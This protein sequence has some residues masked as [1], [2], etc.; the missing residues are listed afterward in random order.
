MINKSEI[1]AIFSEA[2]AHAALQGDYDMRQ[3]ADLLETI[4]SQM[5]KST[6]FEAWDHLSLEFMKFYSESNVKILNKLK[7]AYFDLLFEQEFNKIEECRKEN[8]Q[9]GISYWTE[10]YGRAAVNFRDDLISILCKQRKQWPGQEKVVM[11]RYAS[12]ARYMQ[13]VRWVDAFDLYEEIEKNEELPKDVRAIAA[14]ILFE[15]VLYY[16]PDYTHAKPYL[17]SA[18]NLCPDHYIVM[19][20]W[21]EWYVKTGDYQRARDQ[22]LQVLIQKSTDYTAQNFMGDSFVSE[23]KLDNAEFWFNTARQNNFL[24]SES[25]RRL[26]NLFADKSLFAGKKEEVLKL[27]EQILQI[28][29]PIQSRLVEKGLAENRFFKQAV[30]YHTYRDVAAA[31]FGNGDFTNSEMWYS[32]AIEEDP[33]LTSALID[34]ANLKVEQKEPDLDGANAMFNKVLQ[35]DPNTY[36][37][38]WGLARVHERQ[39][40]IESALGDFQKCLE[41]RPNWGDWIN[42]F[43]GNLYYRMKDFEKAIGFYE[44]A[45]QSNPSYKAYKENLVD[46]MQLRAEQLE[47]SNPVK[48]QELMEKAAESLE[49]ANNWNKLGNFYYRREEYSLAADQY[50]KAIDLNKSEPVYWE[51]KGL[52]L[53]RLQNN[54]EA[55]QCYHQ[56]EALDGKTGKYLNRIGYFLFSNNR[57]N[58]AVEYYLK[59][60]E[61]E[62]ENSI[63]LSNTGLA[64][65]RLQDWD[66]AIRYYELLIQ[67]KP[68]DHQTLNGIGVIYHNKKDYFRA[69]E[70][71]KR[72]LE[73]KKEWLYYSNIALAY[74]YLGLVN[75]AI[76]NY[77]LSNELNPDD[78]Y[79][80]N[81]LG[82]LYYNA[83]RSDEAIE[84]YKRSITL[85]PNDGVLYSNLGLALIQK[86]NSEEVIRVIED[87]P[88]DESQKKTAMSVVAPY[89]TPSSNIIN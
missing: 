32:K 37:A 30:V 11:E 72:A 7:T 5:G 42:N 48:A 57:Y 21:G 68:D 14:V 52:A 9:K 27:V 47:P 13:D 25:P 49:S 55:E 64:Y 50:G 62:P 51:N 65:Q 60:L 89:L 79:N 23:A 59:A 34:L 71:Y 41:L 33:E 10:V 85:H 24:Q 16:F 58:E 22:I 40:K 2:Y 44:L 56:A 19:R 73:I 12:L 38:Y 74:T 1:N 83:G 6:E 15:I 82:I 66:N 69:I 76:E 35:I 36:D 75:Q 54:E 70:Y 29:A 39:N 46:A 18:A 87:A 3:L 77:K 63:Y 80:W 43:I 20:A 31:Y 88:I 86:G 78:Y 81:E 53:E 8:V 84:C 4:R 67:Q 28:C 45:V 17:E 61:R 26:I